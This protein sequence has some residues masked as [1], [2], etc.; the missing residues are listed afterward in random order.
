M[1]TRI[2]QADVADFVKNTLLAIRKGIEDANSAGLQSE[3][4][5]EAS[6]TLE[7]VSDAQSL[8]QVTETLAPTETTTEAA[9]TDTETTARS[10]TQ[11]SGQSGGDTTV[12]DYDWGDYGG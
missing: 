1:A 4:P 2:L 8:E 3:L 12:R 10:A 9:A 6:F 11:S 5:L 7:I